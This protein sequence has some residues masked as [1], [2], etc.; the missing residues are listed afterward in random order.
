MFPI[1]IETTTGLPVPSGS[2]PMLSRGPDAAVIQFATDGLPGMLPDGT[3]I[4]LSV[5]ADDPATPVATFPGWE[6]FVLGDAYRMTINP[7]LTGLA[8]LPSRVLTARV[9]WGEHTSQL[10]HIQF[11][12][13]NGEAPLLDSAELEAAEIAIAAARTAALGAETDAENANTQAQAAQGAAQSYSGAAADSAADA[14]TTA[15]ILAT[16]STLLSSLGVVQEVHDNGLISVSTSDTSG[17]RRLLFQIEADG[18]ITLDLSNYATVPASILPAIGLANLAAEVTGL[19]GAVSDYSD[20]AEIY[21]SPAGDFVCGVRRDRTFEIASINL[22]ASVNIPEVVT[23]RGATANLSA[24][25]ANVVDANG[26]PMSA[27]FGREKLITTLAKLSLLESG[28]T[29]TLANVLVHGDSYCDAI[30]HWLQK[31]TQKWMALFGNGGP[32]FSEVGSWDPSTMAPQMG[33]CADTALM[34]AGTFTGTMNFNGG[35]WPPAANSCSNLVARWAA[36]ATSGTLTWAVPVGLASVRLA[37][38]TFSGGGTFSWALNGGS[39]NNVSTDAAEGVGY[40][41]IT[42]P[43]G[44]TQ[45]LVLTVP[46]NTYIIGLICKN[47]SGVCVHKA[48]QSGGMASNWTTYVRQAA[49]QSLVTEIAPDLLVLS[50]TTNEMMNGVP[51]PTMIA[52]Y[53]TIVSLVRA[54]RPLCDVL[55]IQPPETGVSTLGRAYTWAQYDAAVRACAVANGYAYLGV[56]SFFGPYAANFT[57]GR[58]LF[59]ADSG[60]GTYGV[61]PNAA[62][63][64]FFQWAVKQ[65]LRKLSTT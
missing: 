22:P 58:N 37:Y 12:R 62:G 45:N 61:H 16:V 51:P 6:P 28:S 30:V 44:S 21:L 55:L 34:A 41:T 33:G 60:G 3:S 63:E 19:I 48:A 38:R 11:G 7:L 57:D 39:S 26:S 32:G 43:T 8:W 1:T 65:W 46:S 40:I 20:W 2:V 5:Y 59:S 9:S 18:K 24:R 4:T 64:A 54:V 56:G 25:L 35:V 52:N 49:Y 31:V 15:T 23:A 36:F 42:P 14:A 53:Q 10:F 47:A 27:E 13:G 29:S 17:K 50:F